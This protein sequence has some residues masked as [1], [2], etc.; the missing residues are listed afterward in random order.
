MLLGVSV[1][2]FALFHV[3][4]WGMFLGVGLIF[5]PFTAG[6][7][8]LMYIAMIGIPFGLGIIFTIITNAIFGKGLISGVAFIAG[9][10]IGGKFVISDTFGDIFA[11]DSSKSDRP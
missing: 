9:L 10:V 7:M 3:D 4:F 2:F 11:K 8:F 6:P 1:F 5:A